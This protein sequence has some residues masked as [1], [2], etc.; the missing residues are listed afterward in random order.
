LQGSALVPP[1][2][3]ELGPFAFLKQN[4]RRLLCGPPKKYHFHIEISPTGAVAL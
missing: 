2:Q 1:N 4:D 3:P